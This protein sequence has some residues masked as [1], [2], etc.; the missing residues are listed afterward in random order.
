[1]PGW[2]IVL[3]AV[4]VLTGVLFLYLVR[5]IL[6]PFLLSFIIAALLEPA[7]RK[8]RLRG[9]GRSPAVLVVCGSFFLFF[10][11]LGAVAVPTLVRE[12]GNLRDQVST[13]LDNWTREDPRQ[14][15]FVRWRPTTLA[16]EPSKKAP[17]DR[18]ITPYAGTLQRF[19]LPAS[20]REI[21]SQYVEP[22]RP[23]IAAAVQGAVLS[24]FGLFSSLFS[25]LLFVVLIP[26][27]V[28]L[29]LMEF[30]NYRKTGPRWIPPAIRQS[31]LAMMSDIGHVFFRYLRGM[32][33]VLLLYTIAQTI[34]LLLFGVPF[35]LLLGPIFGALYLVPYIGNVISACVL[36]LLIGMSN[37]TGNFAIHMGSPWGYALL[38]MIVYLVVG[39]IFD[40]L[41][42]PQMVGN[43]VGLSPVVSMFVIFAGGALFGLPGMLIAFPL[44]GSV[45]VVLDRLIK[46]TST[47]VEGLGLPSVPLRHRTS[48]SP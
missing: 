9:M 35:A 15:F 20:Q 44:A 18:F 12:S 8:L 45:K 36:F 2:R 38:V 37:V 43:S 22:Q 46:V 24:F 16:E 48:A 47:S 40:H 39:W 10:I 13:V 6:F 29:I 23:K 31:A 5:G 34:V 11:L 7:V 25:Q 32:A 1:M 17:L 28:P 4:L 27:L 30:D 26:I 3:W 19:G 42:Y 33:L 14:N 21:M 41:V